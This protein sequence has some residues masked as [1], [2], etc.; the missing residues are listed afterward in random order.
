MEILNTDIINIVSWLLVGVVLSLI[1]SQAISENNAI[2]TIRLT[3]LGVLGAV[4]GGLSA[5]LIS[6]ESLLVFNI[7]SLLTAVVGSLILLFLQIIMTSSQ[8]HIKTTS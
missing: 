6:G 2:S 5:W 4:L 8:G 7:L 3:G 1:S